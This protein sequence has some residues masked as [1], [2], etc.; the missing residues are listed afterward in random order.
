MKKNPEEDIIAYNKNRERAPIKR[1]QKSRGDAWVDEAGAPM[2][3]PKGRTK[4]TCIDDKE[5]GVI[6]CR[7]GRHIETLNKLKKIW[8]CSRTE[9]LLRLL[10][11]YYVPV[12]DSIRDGN[13]RFV[14]RAKVFPLTYYDVD[15]GEEEP[16]LL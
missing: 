15:G 6:C 10:R 3:I 9:A 8:K 7:I 1:P 5:D 4:N 12:R 13:D 11:P 16:W 14:V 2:E